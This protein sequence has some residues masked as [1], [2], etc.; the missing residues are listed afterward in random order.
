MLSSLKKSS[1]KPSATT[2]PAWH[3]NFRNFERLPDTKVVRTSFFIN[4]LSVFIALSLAIYAGYKEYDLKTLRADTESAINQIKANKPASDQAVALFK[5]FQEQEQKI[6]ELQAFLS[7]S[8]VVV[9][10]LIMQFGVTLPE[11]VSLGGIDFR[12]TGVQLR[13]SIEGASDEASGQAVAYVEILR[14][15]VMFNKLFGD[16]TLTNIVR[17]AGSGRMRFLID[18]KFSV[19]AKKPTGGKK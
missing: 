10:D 9:S 12:S 11:S 18:L 14:K 17:D 16:V 19:P 4:G 1:D 6:L 5:N 8:K 2:V 13:G 15:D 7:T 3:P